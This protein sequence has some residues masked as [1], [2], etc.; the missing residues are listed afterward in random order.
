MLHRVRM[1]MHTGSVHEAGGEVEV[2]ETFIGGKARNMHKEKREAEDHGTGGNDKTY[3]S[4][5][6]A[7]V[8]VR[9]AQKSCRRNEGNPA[10][11]SKGNR[12]LWRSLYSDE[13]WQYKGLDAKFAHE[14]VDHGIEYVHGRVHRTGWRISGVS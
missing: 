4:W 14:M 11:P 12:L 9:S 3:R 5:D 7:S 10:R 1:A 2:D 8:A 13:L 6:S